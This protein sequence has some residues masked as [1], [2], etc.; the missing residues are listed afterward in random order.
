MK[1]LKLITVLIIVIGL[2]Q[3]TK[4]P[5]KENEDISKTQLAV[6]QNE[7]VEI[8]KT[9]LTVCQNGKEIEI[10]QFSKTIEI[11]REKFSLKF[12]NKKNDSGNKNLYVARLAVFKDKSEFDKIE[13]GKSKSDVPCFR[14]G[15]ELAADR[16]DKYETLYLDNEGHHYLTYTNSCNNR[17]NLLGELNGLL[18]LEFEINGFYLDNKDVKMADIKFNEFYIAF[19]IDKNFNGIIDEGELNKISIKIK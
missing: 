3:C 8:F 13:Q 18:K 19:L 10:D 12:Y 17:V 11:A 9:Q 4:T 1:I 14:K 7:N 2:T 15:T 16:N 5:R 6:V